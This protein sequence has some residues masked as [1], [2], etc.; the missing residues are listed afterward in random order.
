MSKSSCEL[1]GA[2]KAHKECGECGRMACKNC[3]NYLEQDQLRF[4]PDPPAFVMHGIF[5]AECYESLVKPELDHYEEV[6]ARSEK[7]TLVRTSYRGYIPYLKKAKDPS[8]VVD[9]AGRGIAIWRLKFLAAWQ[10]YDT[11]IELEAEHRKI[12]N[13]GYESKVWSARG[14]F[15]CLDH[16]KFRPPEEST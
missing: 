2:A 12:R 4:H 16:V 10:G 6:L 15:V 3:L 8:E 13:F 7:I 5:C 1:C 11:V 14:H 9:D